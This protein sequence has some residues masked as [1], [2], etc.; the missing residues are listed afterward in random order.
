MQAHRGAVYEANCQAA[1]AC[2]TEVFYYQPSMY[3]MS[4][5]QFVRQT[6]EDFYRGIAPSVC[7]LQVSARYAEIAE[8][9]AQLVSDCPATI[10]EKIKDVLNMARITETEIP[11]CP[12]A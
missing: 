3:S 12:R 8:Q 10:L 2:F 7:D 6:V 5:N 9:N 1:G 11:R 4:N